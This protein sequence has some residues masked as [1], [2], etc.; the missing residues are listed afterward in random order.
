MFVCAPRVQKWG[1]LGRGLLGLGTQLC[2]VW[3]STTLVV[4]GI[5]RSL[6]FPAGVIQ[7]LTPVCTGE[8]PSSS[9]AQTAG[10]PGASYSHVNVRLTCPPL[11]PNQ[12]NWIGSHGS[13]CRALPGRGN[14]PVGAVD[15]LPHHPHPMRRVHQSIPARLPRTG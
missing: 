9:P 5:R 7:Q 6:D 2:S 14:R 11:Y 13:R 1:H 10:W 8:P 15:R 3:E 4:G 12:S